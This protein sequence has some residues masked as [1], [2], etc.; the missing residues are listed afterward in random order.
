MPFGPPRR[1]EREIHQIFPLAEDLLSEEILST[2]NNWNVDH[3]CEAM[4][5]GET[6]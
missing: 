3:L 1:M 4:E 2:L 5:S 6:S